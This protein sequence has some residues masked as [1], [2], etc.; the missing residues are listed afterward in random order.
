[1]G[2]AVIAFII[3]SNP[4][5]V[6]AGIL[7]FH[8]A[9]AGNVID[10]GNAVR[11]RVATLEHGLLRM[12]PAVDPIPGRSVLLGKVGKLVDADAEML[13]AL[14]PRGFLRGAG[15]MNVVYGFD[16]G[17]GRRQ[18]V[19]VDHIGP[20]GTRAGLPGDVAGGDVVVEILAA[21]EGMFW[22]LVVV[23]G[24]NCL[25]IGEVGRLQFSQNGIGK[26]R[27]LV[28]ALGVGIRVA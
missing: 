1:M 8:E 10:D 19:T 2:D 5:R 18:T 20:P 14:L 3:G 27:E 16:G 6:R 13:V 22:R 9:L 28:Y 17:N 25:A 23:M 24:E 15:G 4:R 7:V 12:S 26:N 21:L 11:E